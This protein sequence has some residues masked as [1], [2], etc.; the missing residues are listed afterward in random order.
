MS[1]E[2]EADCVEEA[3]A[4]WEFLDLASSQWSTDPSLTVSCQNIAQCCPSLRLSSSAEASQSYPDLLGGYTQTGEYSQGRPVYSRD[5]E[6]EK[7]V[8]ELRYV[9]DVAHHWAGWVVG[10]PGQAMGSLSHDGDTD[11]PSQLPPGWDVAQGEGWLA[12]SSLTVEC[13]PAV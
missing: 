12:D 10:Q 4:D 9:E 8:V 5:G 13:S 1:N 6:E 11:C 2:G 3:G 7:E